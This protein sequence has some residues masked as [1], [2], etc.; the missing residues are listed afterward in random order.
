MSGWIGI[1]QVKHHGKHM[2]AFAKTWPGRTIV[3][4]TVAQILLQQQRAFRK[5]RIVKSLPNE[6]KGILPS[7]EEI[8]KEFAE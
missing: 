1:M 3:Q 2:R 5:T 7:V 8:E 6:F 4:Q